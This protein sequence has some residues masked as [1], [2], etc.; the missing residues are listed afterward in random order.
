[1]DQG[2]KQIWNNFTAVDLTAHKTIVL[3]F[4]RLTTKKVSVNDI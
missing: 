1:M 3:L 2:Q 4:E